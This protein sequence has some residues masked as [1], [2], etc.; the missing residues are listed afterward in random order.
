M[1]GVVVDSLKLH[2]DDAGDLLVELEAAFGVSF[3]L[4]L[5]WMTAGDILRAVEQ[6]VPASAEPGWCATSMTFYRLRRA[7]REQVGISPL[8]TTPLAEVLGT[9]Q[10]KAAKKLAAATGL[11]IGAPGFTWR[12]GV[13]CLALVVAALLIVFK[14]ADAVTWTALVTIIGA[15]IL[16]LRTDPGR[17]AASTFGDWVR[18]VSHQNAG[19]M[20]RLGADRRPKSLWAAT[21]S[22]LE[23]YSGVP[24]DQ[25]GSETALWPLEKKREA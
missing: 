22:I 9:N 2:G 23:A 24:A 12:G 1:T 8:P 25:I 11:R 10:S 20:M 16:L 15:G 18:S 14:A 4:E 13:G 19:F 5:P 7:V 21:V 6:R 17:Y 3:G